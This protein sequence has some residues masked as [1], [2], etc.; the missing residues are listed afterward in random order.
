MKTQIK[1]T[2]TCSFAGCNKYQN[3]VCCMAHLSLLNS[4]IIIQIQDQAYIYLV[5]SVVAQW[6]SVRLGIEDP[7]GAV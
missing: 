1:K 7:L 5:E 3:L 2:S 4:R 6:Y